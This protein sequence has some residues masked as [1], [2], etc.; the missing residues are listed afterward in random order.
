MQ[1]NVNRYLF[2]LL[3][4][5]GG[6]K[7]QGQETKINLEASKIAAL[8]YNYD[9]KNGKLRE[10]QALSAKKELLASYLPKIEATGTGVFGFDELIPSSFTGNLRVDNLYTA[11]VSLTEALYTGGKRKTGKLLA[12]I[13]LEVSKIR[14]RQAKDSVVLITTQKFWQLIQIQEQH[15]VLEANEKYLSGLLKQQEDMLSSGLIAKNELFTVKVESSQL[16]LQKSRLRN[17]RKVALLDFALYTGISYDSTMVANDTFDLT[18]VPKFEFPRPHSAL[19]KNRNYQLLQKSVDASKLLTRMEKSNQLPTIALGVNA[20]QYGSF[21]GT[22]KS[23]FVP[24]AFATVKIPISAWWGSEKHKTKQRELNE[25]IATNTLAK[26]S[27][28]LKIGIMNSW[29]ELTDS[30]KRIMIAKET[31]KLAK[32]NLK[33]TRDRY[34]SGLAGLTELLDAQRIHIRSHMEL[35]SAFATYENSEILYLYNT[36]QIVIPEL[37]DN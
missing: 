29:Y 28:Q 37:N 7:L 33:S 10:K 11:G 2:I 9:I 34:E 5:T 4:I 32:V 35:I 16:K 22:I 8:Q 25:E 26:V 6:Y 13:Q 1:I 30:R 14:Y 31:L 18:K 12:N 20:L 36:G 27:D 15:K 24:F 17:L 21:D 3:V 23:N 19:A